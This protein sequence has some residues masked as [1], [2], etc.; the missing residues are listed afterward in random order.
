MLEIAIACPGCGRP[1]EGPLDPGAAALT[2]KAC[3]RRTELP[4]AGDLAPGRM[5]ERCAVCGSADLYVQRD[6][7]RPLGLLLAAVGLALGPFTMWISTVV[8]IAV[9]AVLYV[10]TPRMAVCYACNAQYRGFDP[11]ETPKP[12]DIAIHDAYKFGKRFPPRRDVA[13][14]GPLAKRLL[15]EGKA[16][17]LPPPN[18]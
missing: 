3:G 17:P 12:F 1:V 6:F 15:F 10:V 18:L 13:V 14:A 4:E 8:A 5:P 11:A 16:P 7:N 9:D 2:C